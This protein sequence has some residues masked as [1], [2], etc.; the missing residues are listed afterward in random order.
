MENG[1]THIT[2]SNT[3]IADLYS[4]HLVILEDANT[5]TKKAIEPAIDNKTDEL[6]FLGNNKKNI[7]ICINDET[8]THLRDE[9][10]QL[11]TNILAA[12]KLNI[13]DVAIINLHKQSTTF[14]QLKQKINPTYCLLFGITTDILN[15]S[16]VL[17]NYKIQQHNAC[18]FIIA[19]SLSL[20]EGNTQEA[21]LEKSKLWL[22][23]KQMFHI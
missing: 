18:S 8:A 10:L 3:A 17:P 12:C 23:L 6:L 15:L 22:S 11:L 14:L 4:K 20:M 21:K 9:W 1:L 16:F 2:L 7:A 5:N 19:P 13:G